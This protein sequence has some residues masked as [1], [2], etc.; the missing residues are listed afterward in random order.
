MGEFA[1]GNKPASLATQPI[2]PSCNPNSLNY[3][4]GS[5]LDSYFC[6]TQPLCNPL[7]SNDF[8]PNDTLLPPLPPKVKYDQLPLQVPNLAPAGEAQA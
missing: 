4:G 8:Q 5:L 7:K 1:F 6:N 2:A 3:L